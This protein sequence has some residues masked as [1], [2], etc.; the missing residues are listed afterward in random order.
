[1][2]TNT[3]T[4]KEPAQQM[5]LP[6]GRLI[7]HNLFVKDA[8]E[9]SG[10]QPGV[11]AYKVEMAFKKDDPEL[12][13]FFGKLQALADVTW[14]LPEDDNKGLLDV[15][16]GMLISGFKDGDEMAAKREAAGKAGDAYKGC[17]VL[18][19][20][21][22]YNR[23]GHNAE[24]G[25]VVLGPDLEPIEAV[26]AAEVYP[27]CMGQIAV[28]PNT[29]ESDVTIMENGRKK[30][31]SIPAFSWYLAAFQ[32][33]GEGERLVSQQDHSKLFKPVGRAAAAEGA[34]PAGRRKRAG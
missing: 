34:A 5:V 7:H 1:M 17:W 12:G 11:P 13:E 26:A 19:A 3:A 33:R 32:K 18:R 28:T 30:D 14:G 21:T 31:V 24:G 25:A 6:E 2:A 4:K 9:G 16:G 8:Y 10:G 23:Y 27:G 22:I 15:D 20:K 29:Y